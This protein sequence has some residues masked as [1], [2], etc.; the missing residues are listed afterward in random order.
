MKNDKISD[1]IN[2][3]ITRRNQLDFELVNELRDN[4]YIKIP[5]L[6]EKLN[7]SEP[8]V[9]RH[10]DALA[11]AGIVERIGSRKSGYWKVTSF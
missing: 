4:P 7:K 6:A 5:E 3:K 2:D 8:T 1:K 10:L 11:K 9:H